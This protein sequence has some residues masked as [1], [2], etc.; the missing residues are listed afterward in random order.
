MAKA[1]GIFGPT[2]REVMAQIQ[3]DAQLRRH[4]ATQ[5]MGFDNPL[6]R[7]AFQG[8][9]QAMQ[10]AGD[11]M[12][13]VSGAKPPAVERAEKRDRAMR[14]VMSKNPADSMEQMEMLSSEFHKEGLFQEAYDAGTK[15]REMQKEQEELSAIRALG[16]L[17]KAQEA[18][19]RTA[20]EIIAGEEAGRA[21]KERVAQTQ[22][23]SR[24]RVA[25]I[26]ATA[27]VESA[28]KRGKTPKGSRTP[29]PKDVRLA[30]DILNQIALPDDKTN[31]SFLDEVS[32]PDQLKR[33]FAA[34]AMDIANNEGRDVVDV[35]EELADLNSLEEMGLIEE[36]GGLWGWI[37]TDY[38]V[39]TK[40]FPTPNPG[41]IQFLTNDPSNRE[42]FDKKF[43]P[44]AAAKILGK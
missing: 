12:G 36:K 4:E 39:P 44:G 11:L 7:Q 24:E 3:R 41:H 6:A 1:N 15:M 31:S 2:G 42:A 21:S 22:A 8:G 10:G 29:G 16:S 26:R 33:L 5:A 19:E 18:G 32:D 34:K 13:A 9:Y 38:T 17:R 28:G 25:Q 40:E 37:G 35:M 30:G 20:E 27:R 14:S 43:G 23:A